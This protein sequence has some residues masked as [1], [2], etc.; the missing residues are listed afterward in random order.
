MNPYDAPRSG[1][2][3]RLSPENVQRRRRVYDVTIT[4][5]L[6]CF[7]V[8]GLVGLQLINPGTGV[9]QM[10]LI[11]LGS[12]FV[13]GIANTIG[14]ITGVPLIRLSHIGFGGIMLHMLGSCVNLPAVILIVRLLIV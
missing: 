8:S 4:T 10:V 1:D 3:S 14:L 13:G 2:S 6:V 7:I 5:A 12:C 11:V 9:F